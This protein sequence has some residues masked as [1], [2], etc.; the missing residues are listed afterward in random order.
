MR[1]GRTLPA[2]LVLAFTALAG[3]EDPVGPDVSSATPSS[4]AASESPTASASEPAET[5]AETPAASP[6]SESTELPRSRVRASVLHTAAL[7]SSAATTAEEKAVVTAWM[8]YWQAATNTYFYARA[9]QSLTRYAADAAL[10]GVRD[11][12][13]DLKRK[14]ERV[15]G[16]ARDNVTRVVVDGNRA[17]VRDCTENYTFNVDEEGAPLMMKEIVPWYDVRGVLEKRQGQW[18]VTEASSRKLQKS[19]LG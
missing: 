15:V 9:P 19:C 12:Q 10:D 5:P 16:W 6:T 8:G 3:C 13:A 17:T 1:R 18:I 2:V 11:Y 7:G 4:E 14:Q